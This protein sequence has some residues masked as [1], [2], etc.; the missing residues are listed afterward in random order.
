MRISSLL[1]HLTKKLT[2]YNMF[3]S[4]RNII[5]TD[6]RIAEQ[7]NLSFLRHGND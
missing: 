5:S 4:I 7:T 3:V 1:A 6:S 2:V